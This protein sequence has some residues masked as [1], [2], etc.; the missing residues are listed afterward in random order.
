MSRV[1]LA[2][3]KKAGIVIR[4]EEAAAIVRD[5]CRQYSSHRVRG[6]PGADG[7]YIKKDGRI[8]LESP[9]AGATAAIPAAAGLL[10]N[11][12]TDMSG[13]MRLV[14]ARAQGSL[15]VPPFPSIDEFSNALERFVTVD[16]RESARGLYRAWATVQ[17]PARFARYGWWAGAAAVILILLGLF[18]IPSHVPESEHR[19]LTA[20]S[21][22]PPL[23]PVERQDGAVDTHAEPAAPIPDAEPHVEPAAHKTARHD[24]ARNQHPARKHLLK[25]ELFR[26][27]IK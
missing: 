18:A 4:A 12:A 8:L 15:D 10:E 27:V 13:A 25:R 5:V 20:T 24:A 23:P 6:I 3:L 9:A 17:P 22:P 7:V 19:V 11:L 26:I 16:A 14:V 1:S 21:E 2:E